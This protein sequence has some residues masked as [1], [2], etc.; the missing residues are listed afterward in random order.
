MCFETHVFNGVNVQV[1]NLRE[2]SHGLHSRSNGFSIDE[3]FNSEWKSAGVGVLLKH[4]F[5]KFGLKL[6]QILS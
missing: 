5:C 6:K 2:V 3:I 4:I 1:S